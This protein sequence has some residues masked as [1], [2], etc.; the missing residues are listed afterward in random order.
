MARSVTADS[1][2]LAEPALHFPHVR[3]QYPPSA[4]QDSSHLPHAACCSHVWCPGAA[5]SAQRSAFARCWI[6]VI[7]SKTVIAAAKDGSGVL[8]GR[9]VVMVVIQR[10]R[11][12][13]RCSWDGAR[14]LCRLLPTTRHHPPASHWRHMSEVAQHT[15]V[16]GRKARK[17]RFK[18][19]NVNFEFESNHQSPSTKGQ[20]TNAWG[21]TLWAWK[22]CTQFREGKECCRVLTAAVNLLRLVTIFPGKRQAYT[23]YAPW[24]TPGR[25]T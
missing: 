20:P 18:K 6:V 1:T 7:A 14:Y 10:A 3:R 12:G 23:L 16:H 11:V 4:I 17:K 19:E 24:C 21:G 2:P 8:N 15:G 5:T 9:I 22:R 25:T 13:T